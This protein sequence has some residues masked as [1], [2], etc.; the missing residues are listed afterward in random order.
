MLTLFSC[1]AIQY[2]FYFEAHK[3]S[4]LLVKTLQINT[5][6]GIILLFLL[7]A[8]GGLDYHWDSCLKGY[9]QANTVRL[10]ADYKAHLLHFL[11]KAG[12]V[13]QMANLNALNHFLFLSSLSPVNRPHTHTPPI[14]PLS[15]PPAVQQQWGRWG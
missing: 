15:A 2:R 3:K 6:C 8:E 12:F 11:H 4:V 9:N 10:Q 1:I 13:K 14:P 7:T 5:N